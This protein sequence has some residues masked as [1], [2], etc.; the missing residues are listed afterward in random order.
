AR[1]DVTTAG[2]GSIDHPLLGA[3]AKLADGETTVLTGR[4]SLSSQGWLADHAVAGTVILPGAAFVELAVRAGDEA[5][6]AVLDELV[7]HAPLVLSQGRGV[8]VQVTVS[9][10]EGDGRRPVTVH[11]RPEDGEEVWTLHGEG[12]LGGV[13]VAGEGLEVWPPAGAVPVAV[14]GVYE[15]LA[16]LGLEYGPVFRGLGAAWRRGDDLFAEVGLPVEEHGSGFTLHPALLDACLHLAAVEGEGVRLP[17]AWSGVAVHAS[18]ATAARVHLAVRGDGLSLRVADG[19]GAPVATVGSLSVRPLDPAQL[20]AGRP[21]DVHH[22]RWT[23]LPAPAVGAASAAGPVLF[24]VGGGGQ[25]PLAGRVRAV[26][27][28]VLAA[29]QAHLRDER[30]Q[31]AR[32]VVV[33]R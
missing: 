18:G 14:E 13:V 15:R 7:L 16:G 25:G 27:G 31:D 10:A 32:L 28:E 3:V 5:G 24:A 22:V 4:L 23:A 6:L 9:A 21:S 19:A 26:A 20:A 17:F 1:G 11:S 29:L 30:S 33:T 2:L 12:F 8:Q